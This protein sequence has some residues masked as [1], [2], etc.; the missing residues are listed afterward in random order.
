MKDTV[1]P[2]LL[3]NEQEK[4][5]RKAEVDYARGSVRY[6]GVIL[7]EEIETLNERYINGEL[8]SDEHTKAGLALLDRKYG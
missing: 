5:R 6:E 3:I 2:Y 8:T 4:A 7:C 1:R